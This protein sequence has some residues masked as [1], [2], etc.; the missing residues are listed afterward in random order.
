M[1]GSPQ[2]PAHQP[3]GIGHDK[4]YGIRNDF[5]LEGL[6]QGKIN[7]NVLCQ[8]VPDSLEALRLI[9]LMQSHRKHLAEVQLLL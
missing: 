6:L 2:G 9:M 5:T 4:A 8:L 1:Q 3:Y 7:C